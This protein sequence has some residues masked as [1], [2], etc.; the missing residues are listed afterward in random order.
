MQV[1]SGR[2]NS[3]SSYH[4]ERGSRGTFGAI[5]GFF[6]RPISGPGGVFDRSGPVSL[7]RFFGCEEYNPPLRRQFDRSDCH[8]LCRDRDFV[9]LP[10]QVWDVQR[11]LLR[12]W[13]SAICN[14]AH[15]RLRWLRQGGRPRPRQEGSS[16]FR[17]CPDPS[18]LA[19]FF[20]FESR[21][22]QATVGGLP[23][24]IHPAQLF[25]IANQTGPHRLE[26]TVAD[27]PLKPTMNR[28]VVPEDLWQLVPLAS[29][30]HPKNDS[31]PGSSKIGA[32]P[33]R[34]RG[35]V[36]L[37]QKTFDRHPD[38]VRDFPNRIQSNILNPSLV[39]HPHFPLLFAV[40]VLPFRHRK[41]KPEGVL[42]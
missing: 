18:G 10:R 16:W 37:L 6:Q 14:H 33:S 15:S 27:P 39:C 13:L 26:H 29:C 36:K 40:P 17:V 12:A 21:F 24:P 2:D 5:P 38:V 32:G 41:Q 35:W 8:S 4:N 31:I 28:T 19:P 11:R 20:A 9:E 1:E 34:F 22:A 7:L 25:T 3:P 30:P 23:F 42:R